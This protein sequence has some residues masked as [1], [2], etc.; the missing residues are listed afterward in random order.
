MSFTDPGRIEETVRWLSAAAHDAAFWISGDGR[1]GERDAATLLGW[2]ESSLRNART[3]GR[4][5]RFYRLGGG[6][7]RVTYRIPD[8][9]QWIE[10][11]IEIP[12][13]PG[14]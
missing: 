6:G 13:K 3:E 1:I 8:L 2:S 4:G 5:P 9:A 11:R 12:S 14:K 10:T 7:H